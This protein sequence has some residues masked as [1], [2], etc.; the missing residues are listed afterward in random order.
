VA[1]RAVDYAV[2]AGALDAG[3]AA[4]LEARDPTADEAAVLGSADLVISTG[5]F[6]YVTEA[7]LRRLLDAC[8][9]GRP[10]MAHF[11]LRMFDFDPAREM[12]AEQGYVTEKVE[13]LHP[14][15]RFASPEE[16][17]HVLD[18]LARRG[19]DPTGAEAEGWYLAELHV[20]RPVEDH[21][22]LPLDRIL[23]LRH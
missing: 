13:G 1:E 12:L 20:A 19:I 4:D 5:C 9:G 2:G 16:R 3:I 7:S 10:W 22:A 15:R 21:R 17:A 23:S 6:G 14:Q 11:V 18:N 8:N